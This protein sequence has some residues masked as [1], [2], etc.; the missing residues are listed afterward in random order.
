MT[1]DSNVEITTSV[2]GQPAGAGGD[3]FTGR[4]GITGKNFLPAAG[5]GKRRNI[6][7]NYRNNCPHFAE[8]LI[9]FVVS[10]RKFT[11]V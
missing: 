3:A 11:A 1:A 5:R 8:G 4:K 9:K 6:K 2:I 7:P 10:G